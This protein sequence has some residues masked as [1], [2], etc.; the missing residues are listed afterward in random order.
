MK[1]KNMSKDQFKPHFWPVKNNTPAQETQSSAPEKQSHLILRNGLIPLDI[2]NLPQ[3][4]DPAE[5]RFI[6]VLPPLLEEFPG[7]RVYHE[8]L[9]VKTEHPVPFGD[10]GLN[11]TVPDFII[12]QRDISNAEDLVGCL[13][14]EVRQ[15][16]LTRKKRRQQAIIRNV[17]LDLVHVGTREIKQAESTSSG[18][19]IAT[20]LLGHFWPT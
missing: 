1:L 6:N 7:I 16:H 9:T 13:V 11:M 10:R 12:S 5:Q 3:L 18:R 14:V 8:P 20:A 19:A 15:G 4:P 2:N 17:G